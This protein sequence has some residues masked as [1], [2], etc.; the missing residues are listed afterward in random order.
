M[1]SQTC[2]LKKMQY[3]EISPDKGFF[4][5]GHTIEECWAD[6]KEYAKKNPKKWIYTYAYHGPSVGYPI[7]TATYVI[8]VSIGDKQ[9]DAF[10]ICWSLYQIGT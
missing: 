6:L 10:M 7:P 8:E 2:P 1:I 5:S 3:F 4:I 9:P